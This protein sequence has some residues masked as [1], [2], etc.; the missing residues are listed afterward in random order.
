MRAQPAV[1][2]PDSQRPAA[3]A[4]GAAGIALL[5]ALG[6]LVRGFVEGINFAGFASF[7]AALLLLGVAGAA[8]YWAWALRGLRYE[9]RDGTLEIVWGLTRQVVPVAHI[10]RVVRGRALGLPVV[11]GVDLPYWGCHVG[12][13]RV[14]RLGSVIFYSTHRTPAEILYLATPSQVYGISPLHAQGLIGA[15]QAALAEMD[16]EEERRQEVV[17]HPLAALSVW[18]DRFGLLAAALGTVVALAAVGVVFARYT[19]IPE[20]TVLNFPNGERPGSKTALLGIPA[21][22]I[23]LLLINLV[24]GLS[25]HRPLRPV[26][27]TLLLGGIAV[28]SIL[29]VAAFTATS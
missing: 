29:L 27:Y 6:V 2:R 5:L 24:A 4:A 9:L 1:F 11:R 12:R 7:V 18:A 3:I 21:A 15:L 8:G 17:R 16:A 26:A 28:Q 25:L 14:P 10:E 23:A 19:G 13:A 22:A 20:R